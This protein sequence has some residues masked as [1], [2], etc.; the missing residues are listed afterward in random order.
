MAR[1]GYLRKN[2]EAD[3]VHGAGGARYHMT[4][5]KAAETSPFFFFVPRPN[6]QLPVA[7]SIRE[8]LGTRLMYIVIVQTILSREMTSFRSCFRFSGGAGGVMRMLAFGDR[9]I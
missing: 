4:L 3:Q 7:C 5:P 6:P 1:G 9:M 8:S 2:N